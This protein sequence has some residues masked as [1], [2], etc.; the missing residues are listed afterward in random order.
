MQ[1]LQLM[2]KGDLTEYSQYTDVAHPSHPSWVSVAKGRFE[3]I[4]TVPKASPP[5]SAMVLEH[6]GA[7]R[8]Q[9]SQRL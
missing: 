8:K 1:S 6:P 7:H 5:A 4:S 2:D 3:A 9:Q